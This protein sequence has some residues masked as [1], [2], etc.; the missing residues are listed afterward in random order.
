[1][2]DF[3]EASVFCLDDER[4][5]RVLPRFLAST[6]GDAPAAARLGKVST[7]YMMGIGNVNVDLIAERIAAT[8]PGVR[9]IAL[10]RDPIERAISHYRMSLRRGFE[11]RSFDE[12][13][14]ELLRPESLEL[15]R[16]TPS[17]T[18]SYLVQGEYGRTLAC[19]RRRF[20]AERIHV[21]MTADLER[22]PGAVLDRVL[23]FLGLPPGYRP[24]GLGE[25]HHRGGERPRLDPGGE[26]ELRAFVAEQLLPR[27]DPERGQA[28]MAF[29]FFVQT[30][31]VVPDDRRP[32]LSTENRRRLEAHYAADAEALMELG[33]AVPWLEAWAAEDRERRS[34]VRKPPQSPV[35]R[36]TRAQI[37]QARFAGISQKVLPKSAF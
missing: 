13:V 35:R 24:E 31:N 27:L 8:F 25:R 11:Q 14:E 17:E 36:S 16:S 26:Q 5:A 33:V 1:M 18:N 9:L 20:P 37:H 22:D 3:K 21:E 23:A 19:Y 10:L 28:K 30:W 29:D 12:A 34:P 7:H 32:A 2:P 15:G 4:R 6:F